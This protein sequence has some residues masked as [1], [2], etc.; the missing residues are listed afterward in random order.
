MYIYIYKYIY[1]YIYDTD[2]QTHLHTPFEHDTHIYPNY[3][4]LYIYLPIQERTLLYLRSV[5]Q[6]VAVCCGEL[7]CVAVSCSEMQ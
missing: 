7:Q 5:L 6:C 2:T 3:S 4:S 1:I